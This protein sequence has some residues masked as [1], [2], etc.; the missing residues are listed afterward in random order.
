MAPPYKDHRFASVATAGGDLAKIKAKDAT[1]ETEAKPEDENPTAEADIH[2]LAVAMKAVFGDEISAVKASERLTSS[3]VCLVS[4]D[5]GL[6]LHMERLLKA[7][8]RTGA[9]ADRVLEINPK[10]PVIKALAQHADDTAFADA[11]WLLLD[12]ARIVE[13]EPVADAAA[14]SR[15]LTSVMERGLL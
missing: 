7:H 3:P 2:A 10:H 13:G 4:G 5:A 9:H 11:A 6:S 12:Q 14:F 8:N 1:P 15:R